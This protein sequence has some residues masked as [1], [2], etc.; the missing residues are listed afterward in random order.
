MTAVA[1]QAAASQCLHAVHPTPRT[2]LRV[3][4]SPDGK[5]KRLPI[6][7]GLDQS[8]HLLQQGVKAH[9]V[10]NHQRGILPAGGR[11]KVQAL[12]LAVRQRLFHKHMLAIL[13]QIHTDSMVQ[14]VGQCDDSGIDVVQHLAIVRGHQTGS[15]FFGRG[16]RAI[17]NDVHSR[18]QSG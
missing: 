5:L 10:G 17:F 18:G 12:S 4:L 3:L 8:L 16:T 7:F 15:Q 9:A 14:V 2:P 11:D 1:E 6:L 13:E